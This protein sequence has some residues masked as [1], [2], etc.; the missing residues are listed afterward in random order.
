MDLDLFPGSAVEFRPNMGGAGPLGQEGPCYVLAPY[1]SSVDERT[2]VMSGL[3]QGLA[4]AGAI[5]KQALR[6]ELQVSATSFVRHVFCL[7]SAL[8]V[9]RK[10]F[11]MSR[12]GLPLDFGCTF[13]LSPDA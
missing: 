13:S 6:N 12:W 2:R 4:E 5:S 10:A 1:A 11:L 3:V 7:A 8:D 9:R